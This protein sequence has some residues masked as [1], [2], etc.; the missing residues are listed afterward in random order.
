VA[1]RAALELEERRRGMRIGGNTYDLRELSGAFGDLGTLLPFLAGYVSVVGMDPGGVLV[2]LGLFA[3]LGGVWFRTPVPV[4]PMKAIASAAIGHP[5]AMGAPA[6]WAAG[7]F[8]GVLWLALGASGAVTWLARFTSRPVVHGLVLG[9]AVGLMLQAVELMQGDAVLAV[10]AAALTLALLRRPRVPAMLVLLAVGIAI[11]V[12]REPALLAGVAQVA[13]SPRLPVLAWGAVGWDDVVTGVV[14]LAIPQVALTLGNAVLAMVEENNRL[15][16]ERPL[17]VRTVAL[18]HGLMNLVG[19]GFGGVPLCHGAGGMAGHVRF[20]ART[21]GALV[22]L[23]LLLLAAG[24]CIP[25]SVQAL[26]GLVPSSVLG[27][28]LL[29]GGLEL[30]SGVSFAGRGERYVMFF[31]AAVSILNVGAGYVA[32][33]LLWYAVRRRLAHA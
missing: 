28:I 1:G 31:T 10:G 8:T 19:S 30:A 23:G 4:Q 33:L 24:L 18:T 26:F 27:V 13:W 16:P 2:P 25:D 11:G 32:G 12:F 6:V 20:G 29:F 17:T 9:L 14:V 21:G 5:A 3:I 7:F 15:F 22:I